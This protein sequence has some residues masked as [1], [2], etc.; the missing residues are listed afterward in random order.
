MRSA[1]A[2]K[3][4]AELITA[5]VKNAEEG[6]SLNHEVTKGF[7]AIAGKVRGVVEVMSEIAAAAEQQ[8]DGVAQVNG[9][10]ETLSKATQQNAAT[11][12]ETA[13]AAE[14][15]SGQA[16]ELRRL[17]EQ[18]RLAGGSPSYAPPAAT[19]GDAT[20]DAENLEPAGSRAGRDF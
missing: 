8:S 14:E 20:D 1:E 4:V 2:A 15:L 7:D 17:V 10:I 16:Q 12:E 6:V 13:S 3:S 19:Y 18:F 11:T 5:S 9:N